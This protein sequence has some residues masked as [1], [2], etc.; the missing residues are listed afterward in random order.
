MLCNVQSVRK[1]SRLDHQQDQH[2]AIKESEVEYFA[3]WIFFSIIVGLLA[4][5]RSRSGFLYFL[6]SLIA[7]P[8]LIGIL[9]LVLGNSKVEAVAP[10]NSA[11]S[12]DGDQV[13][14]PECRELVRADARK[15][16]HCGAALTVP[17][18]TVID[19]S[20]APRPKNW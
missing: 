12:D 6:L 9:V 19:K 8:L 10:T 16:K 3:I 15:C 4:S 18:P 2:L 7:S 17:P 20:P 14:C 5:K 1:Q 13:R 11:K